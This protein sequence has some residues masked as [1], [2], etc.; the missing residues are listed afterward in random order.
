MNNG[1]YTEQSVK[2]R[3]STDGEKDCRERFCQNEGSVID[4]KRTLKII[5]NDYET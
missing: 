5:V 3:G 4:N 2:R 1:V